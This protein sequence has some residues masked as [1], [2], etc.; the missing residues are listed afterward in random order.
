MTSLHTFPGR[1][2]DQ[3]DGTE[4]HV[5][6]KIEYIS[7]KGAIIKVRGTGTIDEEAVLLNTGASANY[8][9]NHNTEV[10]LL[11]GGS[12]TNQKYAILTI[13][14]DKQR[15]WKEGT[16]GIQHPTNG[17]L[18]LEFNEKRTHL[19]DGNYAVGDGGT[20]EVAGGSVYFRADVYISGSLSVNGALL[21][22]PPSGG[23]VPVPPFDP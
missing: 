12:D 16:G 18:A 23:A 6:G 19:T 13:P 15:K 10:I 20:F 2:R 5:Y 14:R 22:P 11:A 1:D 21:S 9:E 8:P 4:R 3:Q 17:D 7:G